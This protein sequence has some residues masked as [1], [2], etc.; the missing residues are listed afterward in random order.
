MKKRNVVFLLL[1]FLFANFFTLAQ[2]N[3]FLKTDNGLQYKIITDSTGISV[4]LGSVVYVN[5]IY[6]NEKDT[7]ESAKANMGNPIPI[8]LP[9]TIE[10]KGSLEEG[11][12]LLSVGDSAAFLV[13]TDSLYKNIF[14]LSKPKEI[15]NGSITT[16]YIKVTNSI[17]KDSVKI[18][19]KKMQ[20]DRV[21]AEI[22]SKQQFQLDSIILTEYFQ[23]N[24][25]KAKRTLDGVYYVHTKT[26][27]GNLL[28]PGDT[29]KTTYTGKFLDGTA[30]DSNIG[31]EPFV[32]VVGYDDVIK[33]WHSGLLAMKKGEKATIY[34][35]S[36]FAYGEWGGGEGI[37]PPNTIL[38]FDIEVLK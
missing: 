13:S 16:F 20:K 21:E 3:G 17:S 34:I 27:K 28:E 7:F 5:M 37:I 38:V 22:K 4:G 32:V 29:V 11:L 24:K 19:E 31:N 35:P 15:R 26:E 6:T 2:S 30:F 25:I 36:L 12:A 23:K 9:D 14:R 1:L 8:R 33:G 18:L 10:F